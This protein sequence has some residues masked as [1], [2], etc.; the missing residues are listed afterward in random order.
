M[1]ATRCKHQFHFEC[2]RTNAR[3]GAQGGSCPLCREIFSPVLLQA[4]MADDKAIRP[5]VVAGAAARLKAGDRI[6]TYWEFE[7]EGGH[8]LG[9]YL[10]AKVIRQVGFRIICPPS[11]SIIFAGVYASIGGICWCNGV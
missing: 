1:F 7:Q 5:S 3:A 10:Q 11:W 4:A 2:I 9:D 8:I 6:D